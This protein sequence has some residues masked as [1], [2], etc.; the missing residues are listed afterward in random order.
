MLLPKQ[1]HNHNCCKTLS[2][3]AAAAS[4]PKT[5]RISVG[6]KRRYPHTQC[7]EYTR[8]NQRDQ[9]NV[10]APKPD[11]ITINPPATSSTK[12]FETNTMKD[13]FSFRCCLA[14]ILFSRRN[15][16]GAKS[17]AGHVPRATMGEEQRQP[18]G[19]GPLL[20]P[21]DHSRKRATNA[22]NSSGQGEIVQQ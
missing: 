12:A 5:S 11:P 1:K 8:A 10:P 19:C 18:V 2:E 7:Q 6:Q 4:H 15:H 13:A 17:F 9:E 20:Q 14:S 22:P 3:N 21:Y 16:V